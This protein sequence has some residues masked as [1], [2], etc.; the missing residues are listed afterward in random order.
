[1]KFFDSTRLHRIGIYRP[2]RHTH[3]P[4]L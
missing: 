4:K 1:M 2:Y 3:L